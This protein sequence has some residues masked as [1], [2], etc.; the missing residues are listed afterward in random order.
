[1]ECERSTWRLA[2]AGG[3]KSQGQQCFLFELVC[4][5]RT[6]RGT[7]ASRALYR[8]HLKASGLGKTFE[9]RQNVEKRAHI[10]W[11]FLYPDDFPGIEM[12][13]Q[14]RGN[15]RA[16]KRVKL[17]EEENGCAGVLAAAAFSAKFVAHFSA[18]DQYALGVLH[19]M[20][21]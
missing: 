1:M 21:G 16:R 15:L 6:S 10:R 5:G 9:P 18:R 8:A 7:G 13:G 20:I 3:R 12:F 2:R 17:I 14:R 19:L 11:F 4:F